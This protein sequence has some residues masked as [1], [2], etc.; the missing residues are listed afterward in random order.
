MRTAASLLAVGKAPAVVDDVDLEAIDVLT[1]LH[2]HRAPIAQRANA[3]VHRVFHQRENGERWDRKV[4][5]LH[6][7]AIVD[8]VG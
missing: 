5:R 3:V 6:I 8:A 4:G 2:D 1:R 7:H